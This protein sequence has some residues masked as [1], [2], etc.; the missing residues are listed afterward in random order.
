MNAILDDQISPQRRQTAKQLLERY[1][2]LYA[3]ST[4]LTDLARARW[5][6]SQGPGKVG[7]YRGRVEDTLGKVDN[8]VAGI[9]QLFEIFFHLPFLQNIIGR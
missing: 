1:T 2:G 6:E 4:A 9:R 8:Y 5:A 7:P 3:G